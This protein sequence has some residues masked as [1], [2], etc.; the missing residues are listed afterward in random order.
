M[1]TFINSF[2]FIITVRFVTIFAAAAQTPTLQYSLLTES[3]FTDDCLICGRPTISVPLRGTFTLAV[4]QITPLSTK[5]RMEN[6][7]FIG[8]SGTNED[9]QI[10][11]NGT[12]EVGGE[13][14]VIRHMVLNVSVNGRDLVF[15]NDTQPD[16]RALPPYVISQSLAQTQQNLIIFYGMTLFATPLRE[17]WFSTDRAALLNRSDLTQLGPGDLASANGRIVKSNRE[18]VERL[19]VMPVVPHL[20]VDAVEIAPGGDVWFSLNERQFSETM[21]PLDHGD[22]LSNRGAIV[23]KYYQLV[24]RFYDALPTF[25]PDS[26]LDALHLSD[27]GDILFSVRS[28]F[29]APRLGVTV[30]HGDLLSDRGEIVR[31]NEQLLSAFHPVIS[32]DYGLDALY[33]WPGGEVWFSTAEGFEDAQLGSV[34][35]GDILSTAGYI[36]FRNADLLVRFLPKQ[37]NADYGTDALFVVTDLSEADA[38]SFT[39]V[40]A[41]R[42][43]GQIE[44]QWQGRGRVFQVQKAA[45]VT[46]PYLPLS[47]IQPDAAYVDRVLNQNSL[48]TG[49]YRLQQW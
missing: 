3:T 25:P 8:G 43:A 19:G 5:Y 41:P 28:N 23:R 37:S 49:F 20:A 29:F 45:K 26:G 48:S 10:E 33:V 4:D 13:V 24:Q 40:R 11:G 2:A 31:S 44:L 17:V 30:R 39:G 16:L 27:K 21:G 47:P 42:G 7:A 1:K 35:A 15:T 9:Y 46:G 12:Y 36:A 38:P 14:A 6:I 32:K 18:L 22:I 34:A